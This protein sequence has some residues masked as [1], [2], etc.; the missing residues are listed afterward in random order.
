MLFGQLDDAYPNNELVKATRIERKNFVT[1]KLFCAIQ[2]I[3]A[4]R[5]GWGF[6]HCDTMILSE[7]CATQWF[8]FER[9]SLHTVSQRTLM[10]AA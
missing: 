3:S 10:I 6:G 1:I 5:Q 7:F 9:P 2:S 4:L 8:F